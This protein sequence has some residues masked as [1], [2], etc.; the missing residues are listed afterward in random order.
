M[1]LF[2]LDE[3]VTIWFW[4][5]FDALDGFEIDP[6]GSVYNPMTRLELVLDQV[7]YGSSVDMAR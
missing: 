7:G 4:T 5:M 6:F 3:P 1:T 2:E